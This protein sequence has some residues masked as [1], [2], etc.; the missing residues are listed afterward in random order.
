MK[1][2]FKTLLRPVLTILLM[3]SILIPVISNVSIHV[4]AAEEF[5][6]Y[7]KSGE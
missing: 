4:E 1:K 5:E 2:K 7:T 3:L 6:A